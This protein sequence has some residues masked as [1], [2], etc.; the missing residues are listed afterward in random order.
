MNHPQLDVILFDDDVKG[1]LRHH[2]YHPDIVSELL[3]IISNL[4]FIPMGG[5]FDY[6]TSFEPIARSRTHLA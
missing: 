3:F 6:I 1:A 5:N 2:K 4:L